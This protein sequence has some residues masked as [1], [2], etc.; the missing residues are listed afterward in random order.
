MRANV[1]SDLC[2]TEY[3]KRKLSED[4]DPSVFSPDHPWELNYLIR[5]IRKNY[6]EYTETAAFLSIRQATK[7]LPAPR[8]RED[9]VRFVVEDLLKGTPYRN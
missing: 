2:W 1:L 4:G 5:L 8:K 9:F 6:S 7:G 3:E